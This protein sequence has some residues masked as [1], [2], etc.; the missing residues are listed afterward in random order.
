M[1]VFDRIDILVGWVAAALMAAALA[2]SAF[3]I[4]GRYLLPGLSTNWV[5]EVVIFLVIWAV[6]LGAARIERRSAHIRV[7][8]L[9][10]RLPAIG[11][12]AADLTSLA[13]TLVVA[14][15]LVAAGWLV[16]DEAMLWDERSTSTLQLPLWLYYS[17]L[18][19][20]FVLQ[21]LFALE[22]TGRMITGAGAPLDQNHSLSD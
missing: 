7:D 8:F 1:R 19:A 21:M 10:D 5:S 22:R 6:L 18:P 17:A 11:R 14:V 15:A 3:A 13:L 9:M 2:I 20:S 16:V 12:R 4:T